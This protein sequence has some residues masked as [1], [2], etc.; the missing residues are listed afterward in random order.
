MRAMTCLTFLALATCGCQQMEVEKMTNRL[1]S[2]I[3][4]LYEQ[5][6]LDN[7]AMV[8]AKPS[9]IP[10]FSLLNQGTAGDTRT[11][12]A[13]YSPGWDFIT[14]TS[15]YLGLWMFDKQTAQFQ[16]ADARAASL[17]IAPTNDP[18]RLLLVRSALHRVLGKPD[19]Y[20]GTLTLLFS[21]KRPSWT[22]YDSMVQ[23]GWLMVGCKCDVPKHTCYVVHYCDTYVWVPTD[24][25]DR[26][27]D[28]TLGIMDILT[29]GNPLPGYAA[30]PENIF[31]PRL[32]PYPV[33]TAPPPAGS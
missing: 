6:V 19:Q 31:T 2:A 26:L 18:D 29:A 1:A 3:P 30:T 21:T 13:N 8:A 28:L 10:Y 9:A 7:L 4:S 12:Q 11:L 23:P 14:G 27:A 17:Q 15:K 24:Q 20:D 32:L 22:H 5:E 25:I 16:G 33:P